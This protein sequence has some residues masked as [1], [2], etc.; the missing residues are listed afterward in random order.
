MRCDK[1]KPGCSRCKAKGIECHYVTKSVKVASNNHRIRRNAPEKQTDAGDTFLLPPSDIQYHVHS[2]DDDVTSG[3]NALV[4]S[5]THVADH[6]GTFVDWN[7]SDIDVSGFAIP[8]INNSYHAPYTDTTSIVDQVHAVNWS[9]PSQP[10]SNPRYL[11]HRPKGPPDAQRTVS[12]IQQTLKSYLLTMMRHNALPPFI[13]S[14]LT[15]DSLELEALDNC[16]TLVHMISSGTRGSRKLFWKNV[17]I[18]CE[19]LHSEAWNLSKWGLLAA[20]QSVSIYIL[21][22]L[23]EGEAEYNNFDSLMLATV[24]V[25][26][27]L[28]LQSTLYFREFSNDYIQVI[29]QQLTQNDMASNYSLG[30]NWNDWLY[31]ES[32]RR[33]AVIYRVMNI[34]VYFDPAKMCNLPS[35]L[36]LAPLPTKKELWEAS[37][38]RAWNSECQRNPAGRTDFG[39]AKGGELI[40]LG[41]D[42]R[43]DTLVHTAITSTSP[44][45]HCASW[46]EWCSGMDGFGRLIMLTALLAQ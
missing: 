25:N 44:L 13:H 4:I 23:D 7:I 6:D 14:S 12:L 15:K 16:I 8:E 41:S 34:L 18:E 10:T 32:R 17:K 36:V 30:Q 26:F 29:A 37:D 24:A 31:E 28:T 2:N 9:I 3:D 42:C 33:L 43:G 27:I 38:E 35:D 46:E 1:M 21:F 19:R 39:L 20:M 22:R 45:R 5:E 40:R 11:N